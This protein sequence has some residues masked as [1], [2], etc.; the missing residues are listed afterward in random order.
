MRSTLLADQT[1]GN[2]DVLAI[3]ETKLNC[4]Q[5]KLKILGFALP[6]RL[7]QNKTG[8]RILFFVREDIPKKNSLL[9]RNSLKL[10]FCESYWFK[11]LIKDTTCFENL[12]N[13]FRID[14]IL[15]HNPYFFQN[16]CV[17]ETGLSDIYKMIVSV[18]KSTFQK[19]EP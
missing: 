14:L 11:S 6:F 9:K 5:G 3:S 4:L 12:K 8:D 1:K 16:S 15:T 13:P 17:I 19:L 2:L 10:F 18:M 7:D